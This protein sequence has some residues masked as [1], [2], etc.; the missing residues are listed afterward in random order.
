MT[1][2]GAVQ[3][4]GPFALW[5]Q[6]HWKERILKKGVESWGK[7]DIIAASGYYIKFKPLSSPLAGQPEKLAMIPFRHSRHGIITASGY[8]IKFKPFSAP[9]AGQPEKLVGTAAPE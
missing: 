3:Q 1:R 9:M 8:Y 5:R 6:R 7:Y 2:S 4:A